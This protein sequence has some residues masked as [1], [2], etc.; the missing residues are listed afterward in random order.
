MANNDFTRFPIELSSL[1][2]L[3]LLDLSNN[4]IALLPRN[5]STMTQ[6]QRLDLSRCAMNSIMMHAAL[7]RN[8]LIV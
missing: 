6:L 2:N 3:R 1:Q 7:S 8:G 4:S 5:I